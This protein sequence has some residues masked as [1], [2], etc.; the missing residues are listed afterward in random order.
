MKE[1]RISVLASEELLLVLMQ[2][3][4]ALKASRKKDAVRTPAVLNALIVQVSTARGTWEAAQRA[5]AA[6]LPPQEPNR[7]DAAR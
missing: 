3:A 6:A 5:K 7:G 1:P 2:A 4:V